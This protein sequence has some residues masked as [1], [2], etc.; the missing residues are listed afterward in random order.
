MALNHILRFSFTV[1]MTVQ[2][3][4]RV[5][6]LSGVLGGSLKSKTLCASARHKQ[7]LHYDV[8]SLYGL[9]EAKATA[10]WPPIT[11]RDFCFCVNTLKSH[12]RPLFPLVQRSEED[13]GKKTLYHLSLHLPQ[14]GEVLWSLA[15]RQQEPLERHAHVYSRWDLWQ[16][17]EML[18]GVLNT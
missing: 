6:F 13:R 1:Q 12:S 7:Y 5:F 8:H 14:S 3:W 2:M 16:L 10:R 18:A 15:R 11:H 4:Y 17:N 9:M